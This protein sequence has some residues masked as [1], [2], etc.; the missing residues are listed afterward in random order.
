[1]NAGSVL[2]REHHGPVEELYATY[3][4]LAA[5][6][7]AT[8]SASMGLSASTTSLPIS[9]ART[10]PPG[11]QKSAGQSSQL[12]PVVKRVSRHAHEALGD[13][14]SESPSCQRAVRLRRSTYPGRRDPRPRVTPSLSRSRITSRSTLPRVTRSAATFNPDQ[15]R[16]ATS[17]LPGIS[18]APTKLALTHHPVPF[19]N[20]PL[21]RASC[22]CPNA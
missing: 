11:A 17:G 1:M 2:T 4:A 20:G 13:L 21:P 18:S 14:A 10:V 16:S 9:R 5:T 12:A 19:G 7:P 8:N 3:G 6:S 15:I 22:T